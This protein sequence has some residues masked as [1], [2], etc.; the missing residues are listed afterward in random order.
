MLC[1]MCRSRALHYP[2]SFAADFESVMNLYHDL[3]VDSRGRGKPPK[4][5]LARE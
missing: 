1:I 3:I 2:S 5:S 4:F